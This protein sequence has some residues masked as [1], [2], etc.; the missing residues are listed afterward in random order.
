[1]SSI[2]ARSVRV[3]ERTVGDSS[4]PFVIAETAWAHDGKLEHALRM[5]DMAAQGGVDALNV[6]LTH[7]PAY[8]T[9]DYGSG[10]GR[11]SAGKETR[12]IFDYL[13]DIALDEGEWVAVAERVRDRGLA[14]SV[15]CNDVP[16]L[17]MSDRLRPD[18]HVLAP[19]CV[20]DGAF[21]ADLAARRLPVIVSIGGSTL[22][23]IEESIAL[24]LEGGAPG[25][26][27]QYG[28]QAYPT[29]PEDL[30][31]S[32]IGTLRDTFGWPV[33][34]HDHTDADDPAAIGLPLVA[35][36]AGASVL[37]KHITH[38]RAARGEDFESA[39]SGDEIR[40]FVELVRAVSPAIG[41]GSWRPLREAE[42]AYRNVVRKRAVAAQEISIGAPLTAK[43]VAFKR[44]DA[45]LH[46]EEF[47][48]V[49]GRPSRR[50][51][52]IDD[53]IEWSDVG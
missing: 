4:T 32:F 20:G 28:Y 34:Y 36:G 39:L 12:P 43:N 48:L 11:V 7:M 51:R 52:R 19:A 3:G 8:M 35:L 40:R 2:S 25:V 44:G 23:E 47:R 16:S 5:V 22:G 10:P 27:V 29:R 17:E 37:E 50:S 33:G 49:E 45:G 6:H 21:V 15:M 38:D 24:C 31:L 14:L 1:M 53:P 18:L 9:R 46:A 42:R 30:D 13:Q 41:S 26:I